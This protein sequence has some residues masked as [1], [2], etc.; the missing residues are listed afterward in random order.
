MVQDWHMMAYFDDK[1]WMIY[2]MFTLR[3]KI[4]FGNLITQD[5][6]IA[7]SNKKLDHRRQTEKNSLDHK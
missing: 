2:A 1:L 4:K 3:S 5:Q 6:S 7:K